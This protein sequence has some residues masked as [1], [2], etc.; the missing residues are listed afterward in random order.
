MHVTGK[1]TPKG[2]HVDSTVLWVMFALVIVVAGV[3]A[4]VEL[5]R[6]RSLQLRG[7]FGAEYDRT[8]RAE[9]NVR[10][11][12][13]TLD[14]RARR[15]QRLQIRPLDST[16]AARFEQAWR[17][18]QAQFVDDPHGAVT[19]GDRLVGEV[20]TARGYPV[21]DFEQR[22]ADISV[23]HPDVVINYRAARDIALDH[24][25][26]QASTEDLRQALVHYRA[27]FRD[28]LEPVDSHAAPER[29]EVGAERSHR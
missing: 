22:V 18:V 7:R 25:R 2:G 10:K 24:S 28:L 20:M 12:E 8:V 19:R 9:G 26:G 27:L 1:G 29:I 15:V 5:Q 23:D 17:E 6:R 13:A 4:W 16:D 11:A 21:A 3:V 14:A